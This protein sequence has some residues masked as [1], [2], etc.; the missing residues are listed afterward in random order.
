MFYFLPFLFFLV[1]SWRTGGLNRSCPVGEGG[2][3]GSGEEAGKG[4]R[5]GNMVQKCVHLYVKCKNDTCWN[6]F[7]NQGGGIKD[8]GGGSE[9][10]YDIFDTV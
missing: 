5:R 2:T 6:C 10:M 9:F 8:R 3:S 7:K 4:D 1:Q